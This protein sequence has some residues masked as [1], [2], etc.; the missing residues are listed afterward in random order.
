MAADNNADAKGDANDYGSGAAPTRRDRP[1]SRAPAT[2]KIRG[3]F[4]R[5]SSI[6]PIFDIVKFLVSTLGFSSLS[7]S[8]L[9]KPFFL[10]YLFTFKP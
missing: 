9:F 5:T 1:Q 8:S 7:R 6:Q 3:P 4:I 2:G 10:F